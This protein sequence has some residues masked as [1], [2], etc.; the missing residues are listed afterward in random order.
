[1]SVSTENASRPVLLGLLPNW[2]LSTLV[3]IALIGVWHVST[4]AFAVPAYLIPTPA[5]VGAKIIADLS[6]GA[7]VPHFM[8]TLTEVLIGFAIAAVL[9]VGIGTMLGLM[10]KVNR[11]LYPIILAFQ[12]VPKVALAPL[13]LIWFGFGITSKIVT[14]A[15]IVF[16][17]IL[18]NVVVGLSTVDARRILLMRSL[19][20]SPLQ[21][22]FKVRFPSLLPF[23]FAGLEV[24]I[25]FSVTGAIVGEFIGASAG[26]GAIIVQ[27]QAMADVEGV[28]SVLFFMSAMGL[29]LHAILK[30]V[31]M[32]LVAW[33]QTERILPT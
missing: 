1:M 8:L 33:S 27:R 5:S 29:G 9:G 3:V 12:T 7:I 30:L 21:T 13:F 24:A 28:F 31:S 6:S 20:A 4:L 22:Y 18:V 17:P 23:L 26:L 16:F 25:V 32:P 19:R 10:P 11:A 15:T 2:L 14:V